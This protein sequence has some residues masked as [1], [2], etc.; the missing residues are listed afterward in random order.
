MSDEHNRS[1]CGSIIWS[2][3]SRSWRASFNARSAWCMPSMAFPSISAQ[4]RPLVW[5]ASRA[6]ENRPPGA[7]SC[8]FTVQPPGTSFSRMIDLA[9]LKG[10]DLRRM[11]QRM[12]MIFQ[13]PYASLNP[14]MTIREIV[15]EPLVVHDIAK[16]KEIDDRVNQ[17]LGPGALEPWFC[18]ALS[19]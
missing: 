5:W 9:A 18:F 1:C 13:D 16:S 14:R 11:R 8:S 7:R 6:A 10:E 19:A 15:G 12:Q 2:S 17:L 3:I 4:A